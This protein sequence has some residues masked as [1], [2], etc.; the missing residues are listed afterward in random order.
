MNYGIQLVKIY[1]VWGTVI[2]CTWFL[3]L[4]FMFSN[5]A[6]AKGK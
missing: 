2:P 3:L 6:V 4:L 1:S 5:I